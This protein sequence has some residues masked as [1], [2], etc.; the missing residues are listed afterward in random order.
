MNSVKARVAAISLGCLFI[1]ASAVVGLERHNQQTTHEAITAAATDA[2]A[3][4]TGRM[5]LYQYGLRG[6][7][8]VAI[9]HRD[10]LSREMF[11]RYSQT[12]DLATEFPGAHGFGIIV[13]VPRAEETDFVQRARADGEP[14]FSIRELGPNQGE[15][16]VIKYIEPQR[17]NEPAVGLDIASESNRREAA[18]AAI[19][20]GTAQLTAPITLVQASGRLQQSFLLLMPIYGTNGT[21]ATETERTASAVGW[22]YAPLLMREV[23]AGLR[24]DNQLTH[25]T[26]RDAAT[27]DAE[28]FYRSDDDGLPISMTERRD[29]E[30][31]GRH[32]RVEFSVHPG[33][34]QKLHLASPVLLGASGVLFSFLLSL[35]VATLSIGSLR[36]QQI[37]A[38]KARLAA[39]I[40]SSADGI[41]GKT[42]AGVIT[43]WNNGAEQIF[44]FTAEQA[45]GKPVADL[46][47]PNA[48]QEE[49]ADIL[50]RI[51]RGEQAQH[52]STKRLHKSGRLIDVL[53]TV[54]PIR[55]VTGRVIGAS[56]TVR[57]IS[58]QIAAEARLRQL[59]VELENRVE[60]RAGELRQVN[61]LLRSVLEAASEVSI[62]ATDCNGMIRVFN[63]GAEN[64]LGYCAAEIVDKTTP[65]LLH[66]EEEVR[67]RGLQ[68]TAEYG[69]PVEGFRVFVHK[70]EIDGA[71]T[72]EWTYVRK[73]G[74]Q[75]PVQLVATAIRNETG[76]I[77]GYLGIA[78]DIT[79]RRRAEQ[80]L[81]ANLELTRAILDTAVHPIV[82]IDSQGIIR[83]V[84]NSCENQFGFARAEMIGNNV[85][86]LM[87]EPFHSEHDNY[88]SRYLRE[89]TPRIIGIG[90]E[91]TAKRK[92]GT[93]FPIQ[94][95]VGAMKVGDEG[96]FV[97]LMVD[98]SAL[99]KQR[100]E[101]QLMSNQLKLASE[102]AEL[103]IWNWNL[104][105]NSLQWND[106]LFA[107][108][109]WPLTL[110]EQG[111]TYEHWRARVHPDDVK[112][113]EAKMRAAIAGTEVY[114]PVFRV[115][116]TNGNIIYLQAAAQIE[117]D[118]A[119]KATRITGTNLNITAQRE[120]ETSLR[121]A[122]IQAEAANEAKSNFLANMSHEIRTP[123]NA[124]L[125]MLHM[126]QKTGLNEQQRDYA[127]KAH[128][129][130]RSLLDL[131]NDILDYSKIEAGKL[132]LDPHPFEMKTLIDELAIVLNGNLGNNPVD[133]LFNLDPKIPDVLIGDSLRLKQILVN[134]SG[135]ALKFT[136]EGYVK[137]AISILA[138]D[139]DKIFL[140]FTVSDTGIGVSPEQQQRIFDGFTQA[141]ASIS[142]R[143]GGTGLGLGICR[144]LTALMD[145]ELKLE[146]AAGFGSR[147]WFDIS[148]AIAASQHPLAAADNIT[149]QNSNAIT[150]S[151]QAQRLKGVRL[152]LV[153]DN[154][155]NRY[156]AESIL[157]SEGA[158]VTLAAGGLEGLE[159]I[160]SPHIF[161]LVLMDVQMPDIDGLEATRRIR[162]DRAYDNLPIVAMTANVAASDRA[163][164][165]AAGM[166]G[167]IAKPIDVG[168]LVGT[169]LQFTDK[170]SISKA[171]TA[172][173][174][175]I[176]ATDSVIE[177]FESIARRFGSKLHK[178]I[179]FL[180]EYE[181]NSNT[182][183][184]T[185]QDQLYQQDCAAAAM[186]A[187][188]MKGTAASMGAQK[189]AARAAELEKQW[190]SSGAELPSNGQRNALMS[191][192]RLLLKV[193]CQQL[194]LALTTPTTG[195]PEQPTPPS[196]AQR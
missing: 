130:A 40:E 26:L 38:E 123:M 113:T 22:S 147:F 58:E 105:D 167:H 34:I 125:G 13:R 155:L 95:S 76:D 68:L 195:M 170:R 150:Q 83:S 133:L 89:G 183:L 152:L 129:A 21:P 137:V 46:L 193:S 141:E 162:L 15:R 116:H 108:L 35:L 49:E 36:K 161:D 157:H 82:T 55:D 121:A 139:A 33:F 128:S 56:K 28:P 81:S 111:I 92:D 98:I 85:K 119:G 102:A 86:M 175:S 188:A 12:R 169:I 131:L 61:R 3:Q 189:L 37:S 69:V 143:F 14:D 53:V 8:G 20:A 171:D 78:I 48:L 177:P 166:N 1:T 190:K 5:L 79:Q 73:D 54:S 181:T 182:L 9:T 30:I 122:K 180:D 62:I 66:I 115:V 80:A 72:R 65:A 57:D 63:R 93:L 151:S 7:R 179:K 132:E 104:S 142:R 42:L 156:V 101:L 47:V 23:L 153:E 67:A 11:Q 19:R 18:L 186:S 194:R 31:Y 196:T 140:R 84:N 173:I 60:L 112:A 118:A 164:C 178:L 191:E 71:E 45:L 44:G 32:W 184:D 100:A 149:Q 146:S 4:I 43:S 41:I 120:L 103:G 106:R 110:R 94:L 172:T 109:D 27:H 160:R 176:A 6:A 29:L 77:T 187:H 59:N 51:S 24:L 154:E 138:R 25:L 165:T 174:P 134:L 10:D 126:L 117:R 52:F 145:S 168:E 87:P 17:H 2:I 127:T 70:P 158:I 75:F 124:V 96:M 163:A 136:S 135:N 74:S 148:L 159:K 88:V 107:L 16:F 114:D 39:I 90:R 99:Y 91:T 192:L 144:R 185:L 64:L 50:A 97:G